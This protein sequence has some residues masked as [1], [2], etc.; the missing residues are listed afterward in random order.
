MN[1][2]SILLVAD[3]TAAGPHVLDALRARAARG[4][5][6]VTLLAPATPSRSG[7]TW[8]E[9]QARCEAKRRMEA[10]ASKLKRSGFAIR[11]VLGDFSPMEAIRDELHE[12]SYDE[13]MISTLPAHFSRWL[14]QDLP[15]RA[16]REF[17]IP[18]THVEAADMEA[19]DDSEQDRRSRPRV[20]L[21]ADAELRLDRQRLERERLAVG[22]FGRSEVG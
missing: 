13:I 19:V 12:H 8:E 10:A 14:R 4:P 7:W 15:A 22:Q 17:D 9:G 3:R 6:D 2:R 21:P 11:A 18:V 1:R 16:G 5:C 20:L